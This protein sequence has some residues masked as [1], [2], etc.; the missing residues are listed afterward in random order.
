MTTALDIMTRATRITHDESYKRWSK[1]EMLDWASEAQISVARNPG[2]YNLT[3]V[4]DLVA[5]AR[6][7]LPEDGWALVT[8]HCNIDGETPVS[9]VTITSRALLDAYRP[10]WRRLP[11]EQLV[12]NYLYDSREPLEFMVYPPNDGTGKVELTYMAVP[13]PFTSET[14]ELVVDDTYIP[15]LVNYIVYRAY[16]KESEYS[17]GITNA[18]SYYAAYQQELALALGV[19]DS[20]TPN[21]SLLKSGPGRSLLPNVPLSAN[22]STE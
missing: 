21:A 17:P 22:G 14:D 15:A 9:A 20:I 3:I 7:S 5:G 1:K 2:V 10:M 13:K 6:Q 4:K 8:V 18:Q 16:C 19:R 11:E 12:E